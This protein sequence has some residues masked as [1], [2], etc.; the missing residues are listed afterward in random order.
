MGSNPDPPS[1]GGLET[2]KRRPIL[3]CLPCYRRRVKA[4]CCTY[5]RALHFWLTSILL[6]CDHVMPCTPCCLRGTPKDC[7]FTDEGRNAYMLQSELV[8]KIT[9]ECADLE[10]RLAELERVGP[11]SQ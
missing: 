3:S 2:K 6:Q 1:S 10:H 7:K 8:K 9:E 11:A 5:L 4:S